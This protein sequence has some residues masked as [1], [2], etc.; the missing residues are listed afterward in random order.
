MTNG[1][2]YELPEKWVWTSLGEIGEVI[3]GNTP[4]KSDKEN[5]GHHIPWVKPPD[6]DKD[7]PI[8]ETA[9]ML[10]KK[11]ADHARVLPPGAVL[12]SCIGILG[13]VGIAGTMLASNQQIN[14]II[15]HTPILS[16]YCYFYCKSKVF[17]EWLQSRSSA[18]TVPIINKSRFLKG[19][20]PLAPV[21]EQARIVTKVEGLL[22]QLNS[23][24]EA[25]QGIPLIIRQFRQSVLA[26]AFRGELTERDPNDES[27]E[28]LLERMNYER[29]KTSKEETRRK[30]ETSKKLKYE[31]IRPDHSDL[32]HLPQGWVWIRLHQLLREQLRNGKSALPSES[33]H[34]IPVLRLSAV[35]FKDFG[36]S[37]IKLCALEKA[38]VTDLWVKPHDIL[39]ARSNTSEYVGMAAIYEGPGDLFTFPDLMIRVR[40]DEQVI[41]S[42]FLAAFMDSAS[43]R[44]Y[45]RERA[46]G[47][48]GSM[49]K[50]SQTDIENLPIPLAPINEQ[51]QIVKKIQDTLTRADVVELSVQ[52][53]IRK[54]TLLERS[55]LARTFRGK[56]V[57][58]DPNDEP[59]SVLLERI[60]AQRARVT[61]RGKCR[62]EEFA[63]PA[64]IAPKG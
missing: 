8:M 49:P 26:R 4:S 22:D 10:S 36:P 63:S 56:L 39:V 31:E 59:A 29:S 54:A 47:T 23:A 55:V 60:R 61:R 21:R 38:D 20:F 43:A 2:P 7:R 32:P 50:I 11:G 58:Q 3:T 37:N 44:D 57:S 9:E 52:E 16:K 30:G 40:A 46:G 41:L 53:G 24:K 64:T 62:L 12:V 51:D 19:P 5:Y 35:T 25:L 42:K 45:F 1:E 48:A 17:R 18:T 28:K 33:S 34:G 27:A 6:L 15:L 14:S 13:K